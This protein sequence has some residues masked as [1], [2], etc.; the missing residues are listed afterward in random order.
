MRYEI[1]A[2]MNLRNIIEETREVSRASYEFAD[3]LESIERK[4]KELQK[5]SEDK[6]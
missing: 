2:E 4:Y 3:K 6:E 1:T 5:E